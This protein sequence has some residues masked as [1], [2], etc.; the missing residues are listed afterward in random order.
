MPDITQILRSPAPVRVVDRMATYTTSAVHGLRASSTSGPQAAAD[1][2]R[3][4]LQQQLD[5]SLPEG[6]H[7][8]LE[9]V[10]VPRHD[11]P[12]GTTQWLIR[13]VLATTTT[14]HQE[15]AP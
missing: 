1:A 15:P 10:Q 9:C 7:A 11:L 12:P 4:K 2:L 3:V 6:T 5:A 13:D 8:H 14:T